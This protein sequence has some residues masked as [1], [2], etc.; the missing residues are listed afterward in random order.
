MAA[1]SWRPKE[2][3]LD[4]TDDPHVVL[5][6][7]HVLGDGTFLGERP[8][9]HELG[10]EHR[11]GCFDDTV[12][13]AAIQ[14]ISGCTARRCLSFTIWLVFSSN[15]WRLSSSAATLSWTITAFQ[16]AK[17]SLRIK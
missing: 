14:R 11:P 3:G 2:R 13:V 7:G 9:Q 15:Q 17:D 1:I 16:R 4:G 12:E 6:L 8:G 10:F 5:E